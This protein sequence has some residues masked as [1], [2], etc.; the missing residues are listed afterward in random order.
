MIAVGLTGNIASGKSTILSYIKK[1]NIPSHDSDVVVRCLYKNASKEFI[2]HLKLIGLIKSIK[3][4]KIDKNLI[5]AKVLG[6]K[7]KLKYLEKFVHQKVS[8][9]RDRFLKKNKRLRKK[10]VFLDIPLLFENN[11][12]GVCDYILLAYCSTNLRK[13]RALYRKNIN[14]KDLKKFIKLQ[15]P[16]R[17]KITKSDFIIDTSKSIEHTY[18]QTL[19]V[20]KKI[21]LKNKI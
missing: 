8:L 20:L 1:Q 12:E 15:I 17:L 7:Q 19:K 3:K 21:K 4:Q 2:E 11:L 18:A 10:I 6:D 16:D 14:K 9:S 5:R 13:A